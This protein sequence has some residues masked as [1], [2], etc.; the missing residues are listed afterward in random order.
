ME[1]TSLIKIDIYINKRGITADEL[2]RLCHS[3][4]RH[5]SREHQPPEA[6]ANR[7]WVG[8]VPE[9]IGRFNMDEGIAENVRL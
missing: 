6:E 5:L 9:G 2:I 4:G 1:L 3:C 8:P 7:R